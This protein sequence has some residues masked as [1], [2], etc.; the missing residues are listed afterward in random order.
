MRGGSDCGV[1]ETV[2]PQRGL[3]RPYLAEVY[4][5]M[6]GRGCEDHHSQVLRQLLSA[7]Q[8]LGEA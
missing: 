2:V 3:G 8:G 1:P 4:S 7:L 6:L 5:C